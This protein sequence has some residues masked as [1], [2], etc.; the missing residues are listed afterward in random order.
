MW[1]EREGDQ[2]IPSGVLRALAQKRR[3]AKILF[4]RAEKRC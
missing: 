2:G 3:S 1:K 4:A